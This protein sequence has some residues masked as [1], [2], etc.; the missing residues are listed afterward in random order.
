MFF[1]PDSREVQ[2]ELTIPLQF[3]LA[4]PRLASPTLFGVNISSLIVMR[5]NARSWHVQCDS[6][7][8]EITNFCQANSYYSDP[9]DSLSFKLFIVF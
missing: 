1:G 9:V 6:Q 4:S 3:S 5:H 8:N 2:V 7:M